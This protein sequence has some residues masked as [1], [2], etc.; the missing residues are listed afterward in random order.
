MHALRGGILGLVLAATGA[1]AVAQA[2]APAGAYE[3]LDAA[4]LL[5]KL[6]DL[7][8]I[9]LLDAYHQRLLVEDDSEE[10]IRYMVSRRL[11]EAARADQA[12]RDALIDEAVAGLRKLIALRAAAK[13]PDE[14]AKAF[15]DRLT[16]GEVRGVIQVAPYATRILYLQGSPRDAEKVRQ[17]TAEGYELLDKLLA[18]VEYELEDWKQNSALRWEL[19]ATG[20][21]ARMENFRKQVQYKMAWV[22]FYRAIA[23]DPS[24]AADGDQ[25]QEIAGL[26]D[27][28]LNETI[29]A[30]REYAEGPAESGVKWW[31]LDLCGK[32]ARELK[33][34]DDAVGYLKR[35]MDKDAERQVQFD[36]GF[37]LCKLYI[38]R[39]RWSEAE[40]EMAAFRQRGQSQARSAE[41][42][43]GYQLQLAF[44]TNYFHRR[45][46]EESAVRDPA[47]AAEHKAQAEQAFVSFLE[48]NPEYQQPMLQLLVG[49]YSEQN[50]PSELP[51][52]VLVGKGLDAMAGQT[53]DLAAAVLFL[54]AAKARED[55]SADLRPL[56]LWNLAAAQYRGAEQDPSQRRQAA[57]HF[58][59]LAK[60]YPQNVRAKEGAAN[61]VLIYDALLRDDP[62]RTD[63]LQDN[64]DALETLLSH[65]EWSKDPK[66]Q[67]YAYH[68]GRLHERQDNAEASIR[69]Y[70]S[71][72]Q[73]SADY[74]L[75]WYNRLVLE[76]RQLRR[77]GA[78]RAEDARRA[79]AETLRQE[80]LDLSRYARAEADK[81]TTPPE[82]RRT[83]LERGALADIQ[84][85]DLEMVELNQL[86]AAQAHLRGVAQRW[87]EEPVAAEQAQAKEIQILLELNRTAEAVA[88]LRDL[89][90][91]APEKTRALVT[92]VVIQIRARIGELLS[93]D[94]PAMAARLDEWRQAYAEFAAEAW[95]GAQ[96][97]PPA[98][99]YPFKQMLAEGWMDTGKMAEALAW[100]RQLHEQNSGDARNIYGLARCN[101]QL[102]D[103]PAALEWYRTLVAGLDPAEK[104]HKDLYWRARLEEVECSF[105]A[106]RGQADEQRQLRRLEVLLRQLRAASP[107]FGG[108]L[109]AFNSLERRVQGRLAEL[110][111]A[112]QAAGSAK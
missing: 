90:K 26:R 11:S 2:N 111:P 6:Q 101:W 50:D 52:L 9:E 28:L 33:K 102:K 16:L 86:A 37:E 45:R 74:F 22:G 109:G 100:F 103:Y 31:A 49:A 46:A 93:S 19:M 59:Q 70:S 72:P 106:V 85:A 58:L 3:R 71:V 65:P 60:D 88:K 107:T 62:G 35:A 17:L 66:A 61:A 78:E 54:Q 36:A 67:R 40:Q 99:Q 104:E 68:L 79:T 96:D 12:R 34:Y 42:S 53:P 27:R 39:G 73:S 64:I 94:D 44:L 83:L 55:L 63:L 77:S 10:S 47:T 14:I 108:N 98:E 15:R 87:P 84:V 48:Q 75:A 21:L 1:V 7:E 24:Q 4:R 57:Q 23:L 97:L 38:E 18:D 110:G 56:V 20:A 81:P 51:P 82:Q 13:E 112:E 25:R 32:A 76:H 8:M 105:E 43:I 89:V 95:Q 30:V 91:K 29:N 5:D 92:G 80:Y 41:E 69:W